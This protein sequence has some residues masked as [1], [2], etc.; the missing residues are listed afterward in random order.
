MA[1]A[2]I[3]MVRTVVNFGCTIL[4]DRDCERLAVILHRT[5]FK[6]APP[7]SERLT[8]EQAE[9]V[10]IMA[11]RFGKHS[12]AVA[13]AFQ[14]ECILRQ[15]DVIGEFVPLDEPGDSEVID[16]ARG[17]KWLRGL[18]WEEIDGNFIL[19]HI[20][21]KR[22]KEI[23]VDLKL[24]PMVMDE[25]ARFRPI[26]PTKGPIIVSEKTGL[27]WTASE[28]R[29]WWRQIADVCDI[30]RSVK[31]MDTR[32]G[33][34]SE[35]TDAGADLEHVRHAA[36]HSDIKMTVRYSRGAEQKIANVQ[37]IRAEYRANKDKEVA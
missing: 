17:L 29:R 19:R 12:I 30:S 3:G 35:A 7:R 31:N 9:E 25:L 24:A 18:R 10:R 2:L 22:Q 23:V 1:H 15:K 13:Q 4:E 21:S 6:M 14:F 33:A 28:F 27:P 5:K 16:H 36:T 37:R 26:I 34:I 20:T 8:A 11:H 32:S